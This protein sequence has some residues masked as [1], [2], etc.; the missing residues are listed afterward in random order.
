MTPAALSPLI[1]LNRVTRW[2]N[3]CRTA[4]EGGRKKTKLHQRHLSEISAFAH[5]TWARRYGMARVL[6]GI[7]E[8]VD[9]RSI[10]V[11][12]SSSVI[13]VSHCE[14]DHKSISIQLLSI[15]IASHKATYSCFGTYSFTFAIS[16]PNAE[17]CP[18]F[19]SEVDRAML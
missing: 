11:G 13:S 15:E 3:I 18:A 8:E 16:E 19:H 5:S 2:N 14:S 6:T 12:R 7:S 17:Q 1:L 4:A 9:E 10:S